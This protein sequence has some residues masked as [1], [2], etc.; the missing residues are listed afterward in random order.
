MKKI[1]WSMA[2]ISGMLVLSATQAQ[3]AQPKK[4]K[5]AYTVMIMPDGTKEIIDGELTPEEEA[6]IYDDWDKQHPQG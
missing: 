1:L 4:E 2:L 3:A 5:A 6:K